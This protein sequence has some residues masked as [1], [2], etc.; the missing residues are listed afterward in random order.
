MSYVAPAGSRDVSVAYNHTIERT[1]ERPIFWGLHIF[2]CHTE[3]YVSNEQ[4]YDSLSGKK[5]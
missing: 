3:Q 1:V 2:F 4:A 5:D